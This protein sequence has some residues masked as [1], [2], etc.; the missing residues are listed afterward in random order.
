MK[1]KKMLIICTVFMIMIAVPFVKADDEIYYC[2]EFMYIPL[3]LGTSVG[4]DDVNLFDDAYIANDPYN[5]SLNYLGENANPDLIKYN[6]HYY[7][8]F[9][10]VHPRYYQMGYNYYQLNDEV[11]TF[12]NSET[13]VETDRYNAEIIV[14][15]NSNGNITHSGRVLQANDGTP[16]GICGDANLVQVI[17]KWGGGFICVH[18]GDCCPYSGGEYGNGSTVKYYAYNHTHNIQVTCYN[19]THHTISCYNNSYCKL[20]IAVP[21]TLVHTSNGSASHT[22]SCSHSMC[23]HQI[24]SNHVINYSQHDESTHSKYC[25]KCNYQIY[26]SHN[27]QQLSDILFICSECNQRARFIPI[28][29]DGIN[30]IVLMNSNNIALY[31]GTYYYVILDN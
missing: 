19:N 27:W 29:H 18:R 15:Y 23:E 17:S 7:T 12:F 25:T 3:V 8:F 11:S 20:N 13:Y 26:E 5:L 6:C 4:G 1:F 22:T 24:I 9:V 16:N 30:P 31:N 2:G 21:H 28:I 14:Y 10:T